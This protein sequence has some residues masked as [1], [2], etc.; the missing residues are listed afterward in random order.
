MKKEGLKMYQRILVPLDGA[1]TAEAVLPHAEA[2]A[3]RFNAQ[4]VTFVRVLERIHI[5]KVE[6]DAVI[7]D[8]EWAKQEI[9]HDAEARKYLENLV[10]H[11]N[12]T[13][14]AKIRAEVLPPGD[15]AERILKY[16][17]DNQMEMIVIATHGRSG[18]IRWFLGSVAEKILRASTIPVLMIRASK[19]EQTESTL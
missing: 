10:K 4:S 11:L 2:I 5:P 16:A 13:E 8:D 14:P 7:S 3:G 19:A 15:T 9:T 1:K 12:L 6:G 18:M 17:A